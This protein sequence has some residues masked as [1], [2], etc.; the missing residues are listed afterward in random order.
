MRP[1]EDFLKFIMIFIGGGLGALSRFGLSK[2]VSQLGKGNFPFGTMSV[3]WIGCLLI[4]FF[5]A[6]FT[7]R[8]VSPEFRILILVGFLGAFTTFSTYSLDTVRLILDKSYWTAL[9]NFILSNGVGMLLVFSGILL[10]DK[11][12]S[13]H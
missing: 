13:L 8:L 2:W 6:W 1:K 11:L 10:A 9:W 4:G 5:S 7:G 12:S 3:N